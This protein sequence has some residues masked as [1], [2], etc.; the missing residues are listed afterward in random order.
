MKPALPI[1]ILLL[2]S[3]MPL[4]AQSQ[5]EVIKNIFS[6][7]LTNGRGYEFLEHLSNRI[8]GR[9][10]GSP[11][12]AAAVEYT[13][14][15]MLELDID[16]V[17]L[18]PVMV[19]H[20]VR[21]DLEKGRIV[22]SRKM[23]S[24]EVSICALGNSIGTG[25]GGITAPVIEVK[26]FEELEELGERNI[27]G[28]MVFYNRPLD[29]SLVSTFAAYG[30]AVN[31]R[32]G[33]P[34]QAAKYGAIGVVVRSMTLAIDDIPHTGSTNYNSEY[35]KI[36]AVAISTRDANL[37]SSL[38]QD[39]PDLQFFFETHCKMM[40]DVLSYNVVGQITGKKFPNEY[41]VVGGHLD[42]W[43]LGDGAHDDGAGCVQSI[44]V[45]RIF[46]DIG[47][48]PNHSIRAVMFMNEEN[49]LRGGRKYAELA[50]ENNEKHIVG[51]ESDRGGFTPKGFT[52][53]GNDEVIDKIRSWKPLFSPYGINEFLKGGGGADIGPL[54]SQ[55][56]VLIGYYP[57]SQ[58]Y[59]DYHHSANDT[60]DKVNK[61][62]LE[63]GAASI[64][65][66][67][68]LLDRYGL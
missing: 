34:S 65:A 53:S 49:G 57:D 26:S 3:L 2:N 55:G 38:L 37:L 28:K 33:G 59:F 23:G 7:A 54:R 36:P 12:A 27:Q 19:P 5:E 41:I 64:A 20:W 1:F 10:S 32:G 39:D 25:P 61:R 18:Q 15:V 63:L 17:F 67:V 58:R 68:Y 40:P 14:Q 13:R 45:L 62:E 6:E 50:Q 9:L 52:I 30:G 43:D 60:F 4:L 31:Q 29:P 44:E 46:H 47:I 48:K 51:I 22:N 24:F 66:L 21:G 8:G 16:T 35:P 56:T 42:S 11:E